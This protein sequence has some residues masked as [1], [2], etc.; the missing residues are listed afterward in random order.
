MTTVQEIERLLD[1]HRAWLKD[2][3]TL[4]EVNG[5]WVE[6][7][8]PYLDRHNDVLQIYARSENGGYILSDDSYTIRDLEASGCGLGTEK[9]KDLLTMTLNGFGV[10]LD[11]ESLV[12]HASADN[13]P[14]RKHNLIQ[15]MLA[16]NDLFYLASPIVQS[17]FFEDVVQWLET[18]EI[19]YT[20]KI[21]FTG[22]SGFDH[23]F[24]FV[25]P[26]SPRKEPERI[27]QAIN[28][29]SRDSA[30]AFIYAWS[31]TREVRPADSKAYAVL[32]DNDGEQAISPGVLDAFRNYN[33]QPVPFS[34]RGEFVDQLAA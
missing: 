16:V 29:P 3:T 19:R 33:I 2:R 17:L 18:G 7:T 5:D 20:P 31:D 11:K 15:A 9:R 27:V 13:F 24:D 21:K 10:R 1:A 14:A 6:I 4:R 22:T 26:K 12:V 25:I 34:R 23:L 28:R 30:E 32:N 8:T